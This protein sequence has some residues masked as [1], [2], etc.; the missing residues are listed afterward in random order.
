MNAL[1][2]AAK[3]AKEANLDLG[4]SNEIQDYLLQPHD[5]D[6]GSINQD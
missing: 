5:P 1:K 2:D 6:L 4:V 3:A